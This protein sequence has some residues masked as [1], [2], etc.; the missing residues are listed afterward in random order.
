MA[1]LWTAFLFSF[2]VV[3]VAELGDKSQR[4]AL[5]FATRY[6]PV[7]VLAGIAVSTAAI[8]AVSRPSG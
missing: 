4:I 7:L 6:R 3:F 5:T 8:N 2:G 1:D